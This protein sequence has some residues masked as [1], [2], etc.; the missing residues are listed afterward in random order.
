MSTMNIL[1]RTAG[2]RYLATAAKRRCNKSRL[3]D[4][5]AQPVAAD[6][7][8][9]PDPISNLRPVKYYVSPHETEEEKEWRLLQQRVDEFNQTFWRNNNLMFVRAKAEYEDQLIA[10]G[11]PVTAEAMSIFYKDFLNKAYD[12][13]MAY[14]REWWRLNVSMLY[15]GLKACVRALRNRS[16]AVESKD[17]GFWDKSFES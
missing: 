3:T 16:T 4:G 9:T 2:L 10:R 1:R 13:Q 8:G 15:P 14:N 17:T 11:E 7:I 12:R 6:M 5:L